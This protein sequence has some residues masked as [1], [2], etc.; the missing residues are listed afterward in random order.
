[1]PQGDTPKPPS[2]GE[3]HGRRGRGCVPAARKRGGSESRS[4]PGGG[5]S[6][7]GADVRRETAVADFGLRRHGLS[8]E[9]KALEPSSDDPGFAARQGGVNGKRAT[10]SREA[11]LPER[12]KSLKTKPQERH[13]AKS[14][15]ARGRMSG[16]SCGE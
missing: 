3:G 6:L 14:A 7:R 10:T 2:R 1:M 5:E 4:R 9:S 16:R 15:L 12:R 11:R 8:G 13:R